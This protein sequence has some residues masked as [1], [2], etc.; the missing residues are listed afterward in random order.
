MFL[1][2]AT[3][4]T[5]TTTTTNNNNIVFVV[6]S[7]RNIFWKSGSSNT[8][9]ITFVIHGLKISHNRHVGK[10]PV[11]VFGTTLHTHNR[12][13]ANRSVGLKRRSVSLVERLK[14]KGHRW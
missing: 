4:T 12:N 14:R 2:L 6:V 3:T 11:T 13:L 7:N 10:L 5:T 8:V 9:K 1:L